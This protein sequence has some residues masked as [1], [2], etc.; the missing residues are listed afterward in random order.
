M[1][2]ASFL[3]GFRKKDVSL[4]QKNWNTML[5]Y[6][7]SNFWLFWLI[8]A[9]ICLILEL[10]SGDF[11]VTCFAIG[12]LCALVSSLFGVPFWVQVVVFAI[13]SVLSIW[14]IRPKLLKSLHAS[15]EDRPSNADALLGREGTVVEPIVQNGS[16]YVKID[17]DVWKAV[18]QDGSPVAKGDQVRVVSMES[19]IVIVVKI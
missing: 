19:I 16:G 8:I 1:N 12:G 6:I 18:T 17:G 14:L 13:C 4:E 7:T 11:F 15:G 3:L 2:N 9:V 5:E 10:S